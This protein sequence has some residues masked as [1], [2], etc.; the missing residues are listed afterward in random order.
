MTLNMQACVLANMQ[1]EDR[2]VC[3]W[4]GG[5]HIARGSRLVG[6]QIRATGGRL[7]GVQ[8]AVRGGFQ[9]HSL[10]SAH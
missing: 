7:C 6:E 1:P 10:T 9:Q 2:C 3:V 5:V 8:H 4:G